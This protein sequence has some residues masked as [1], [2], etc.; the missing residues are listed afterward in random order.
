M[1]NPYLEIDAIVTRFRSGERETAMDLFKAVIQRGEAAP[2]G[3]LLDRLTEILDPQFQ[4]LLDEIIREYPDSWVGPAAGALV[5]GIRDPRVHKD[6]KDGLSFE[7]QLGNQFSFVDA[8]IHQEKAGDHEGAVNAMRS[9]AAR[10]GEAA[11]AYLVD[12]IADL[13]EPAWI[14]FL[15]ELADHRGDTWL[16]RRTR[17]A[18]EALENPDQ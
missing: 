18:I 4:P 10:G 16:G 1:G 9:V 14:P 6:L 11:G 17:G 8:A 15:R 2:T 12:R 7:K 13:R 5:N 3:Y